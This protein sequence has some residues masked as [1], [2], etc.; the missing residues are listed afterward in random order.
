[1]PWTPAQ[2]ESAS[3]SKP[4]P[5]LIRIS[6]DG[7]GMNRTMPCWPSSATQLQAKDGDDLLSIATLGFRG[8]A[9]P[10]LLP[11]PRDLETRLALNRRRPAHPAGDRGGKIL[12]VDDAALL[13]EPRWR[14]RSLFNTR[15]AQILR[16]ES[17]ELSHVTALVTT[18]PW[19]IRRSTSS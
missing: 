19:P 1:M 11:L 9:L 6:D 3:R 17:T 5:P 16:A 10:P 13:A 7:Y 8:E 4:R 12:H 2:T 15:K 14:R 18:T